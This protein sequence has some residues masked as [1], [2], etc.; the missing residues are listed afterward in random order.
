MTVKELKQKIESLADEM[1]VC[2]S[3]HFGELLEVI[4][5]EVEEVFVTGSIEKEMVF[6]VRIEHP[7]EEPT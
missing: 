2:G 7:G 5:A 3:G 6:C 4:N 1:K